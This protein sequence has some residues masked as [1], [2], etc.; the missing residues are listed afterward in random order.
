M[1]TSNGGFNQRSANETQGQTQNQEITP[2]NKLYKIKN[3]PKQKPVYQGAFDYAEKTIELF[4]AADYS[5]LPHEL[6][7]FWLDNMW[8]FARSGIASEI[9][10][11]LNKRRHPDSNWGIKALQAS[12]LPLGHA[13]T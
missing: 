2:Y 10:L 3:A 6:A 5:T 13:A 7:H 12:A 11:I 8:G 4:K 1:Q 9:F